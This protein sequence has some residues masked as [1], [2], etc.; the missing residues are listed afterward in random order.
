MKQTGSPL[1]ADTNHFYNC[2]QQKRKH[3]LNSSVVDGFE[4]EAR[5]NCQ[6]DGLCF[7][8]G[9]CCPALRSGFP[10]WSPGIYTHSLQVGAH[11]AEQPEAGLASVEENL[12]GVP[13]REGKS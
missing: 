7:Y 5:T 1:R 2:L 8:P 6:Q 3:E 12:A 9:I 13:R 10:V 4:G 11:C